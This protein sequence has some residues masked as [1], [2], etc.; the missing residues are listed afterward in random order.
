MSGYESARRS[1]N[2]RSN[3][4]NPESS[5]FNPSSWFGKGGKT[6]RRSHN[7]DARNEWGAKSDGMYR[8]VTL[9]SG[10]DGPNILESALMWIVALILVAIVVSIVRHYIL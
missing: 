1:H 9:E 5:A 7:I 2:D 10:V 8:E 3:A 4:M 6:S